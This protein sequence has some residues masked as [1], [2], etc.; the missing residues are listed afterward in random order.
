MT[1]PLIA[2]GWNHIDVVYE[3]KRV[4]LY[5][6]GIEATEAALSEKAQA[7]STKSRQ[8]SHAQLLRGNEVFPF[9]AEAIPRSCLKTAE[10]GTDSKFV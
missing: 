4:M 5:P 2:D 9:P 1:M 8:H 3:E 7:G 6:N 10:T